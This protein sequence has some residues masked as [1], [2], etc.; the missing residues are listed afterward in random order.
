MR[1]KHLLLQFI[2]LMVVMVV[3]SQSNSSTQK[4]MLTGLVKNEKGEKI[5]YASIGLKHNQMVGTMADSTGFFSINTLP[6]SELIVSRVGYITKTVKVEKNNNITVVLQPELSVLKEVSVQNTLH[7]LEVYNETSS[8]NNEIIASTLQNFV[9][10]QNMSFGSGFTESAGQSSSLGNTHSAGSDIGAG[11]FNKGVFL[12]IFKLPPETVGSRFILK[13]WAEGMVVDTNNSIINNAMYKYNYDKVSKSLVMTLDNR[14]M[15][16][17]DNQQLNGFALHSD[18]GI[19]IFIKI[20]MISKHA[21]LQQ[22]AFSTQKYRLYKLIKTRYEK[23]NYTSNGLI[24]SGKDYNEYIDEFTYFLIFPGGKE[25][26]VVELKRK[27]LK[28]IFYQEADKVKKYFSD[29]NDQF[30]NE[31][32]LI[33]LVEFL[34]Q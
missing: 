15:T 30:I 4:F 1:N 14:Q 20:P 22:L 29:H 32:F 27:L 11:R 26:R 17:V 31:S 33:G 8:I 24:E 12:P 18:E 21:Y 2:L 25:F 19:F 13:N 10:S 23:A 5:A 16:I 6:G 28:N 3:K 7:E 34:N 9:S